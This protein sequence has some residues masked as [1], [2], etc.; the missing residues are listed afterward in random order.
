MI[1][2]RRLSRDVAALGV[3]LLVLGAIPAIARNGSTVD[4]LRASGTGTGG[5]SIPSPVGSALGPSEIY[6]G[7]NPAT[8]VRVVDT[9][10]RPI[11]GVR[12][13][14]RRQR[15]GVLGVAHTDSVGVAVLEVPSG[16]YLR[17]DLDQLGVQGVPI[18]TGIPMVLVI[19]ADAL[20]DSF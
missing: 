10:G 9:R 14:L 11:E 1:P 20:S 19:K 2:R 15:S 18:A 12:V 5:G 6:S 3:L 16:E 7:S 13:S 8:V 17:V 4:P